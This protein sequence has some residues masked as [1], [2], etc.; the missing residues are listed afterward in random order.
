LTSAEHAEQEMLRFNLGTAE[1]AGF[2]AG[3]EDAGPFG[4]SVRTNPHFTSK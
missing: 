2:I 3:N 4:G 1:L